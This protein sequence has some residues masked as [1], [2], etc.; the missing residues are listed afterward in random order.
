MESSKMTADSNARAR[1]DAMRDMLA[2]RYA[3]AAEAYV[4]MGGRAG[5]EISLLQLERSLQDLNTRVLGLR[6]GASGGRSIDV[7]AV[8]AD[9]ESAYQSGINFQQFATA[10]AWE[11]KGLQVLRSKEMIA[12]R[13]LAGAPGSALRASRE[14]DF[15]SAPRT[16]GSADRLAK[17]PSSP[18]RSPATRSPATG[19]GDADQRSMAFPDWQGKKW[20]TSKAPPAHV[21]QQQRRATALHAGSSSLFFTRACLPRAIF[22]FLLT[23]VRPVSCEPGQECETAQEHGS[24]TENGRDRGCRGQDEDAGAD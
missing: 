1:W 4:A 24:E 10:L 17:R 12:S 14:N 5:G 7:H 20:S 2:A 3:N 11:D 16:V 9:V 18:A 21:M 19:D 13:V 22:C 15:P 23:C 8:L 6:R